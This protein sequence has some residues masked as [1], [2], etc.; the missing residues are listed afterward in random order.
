MS[1]VLNIKPFFKDLGFKKV[2]IYYDIYDDDCKK[3]FYQY[4]DILSS[5]FI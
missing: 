3:L 5:Q 2:D 1:D 4:E